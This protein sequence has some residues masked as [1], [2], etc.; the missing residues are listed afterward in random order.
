MKTGPSPK[1]FRALF[2]GAFVLLT[3]LI[4]FG[5]TEK[6]PLDESRC[7]ACHFLGLLLQTAPALV[8]FCVSFVVFSL[9]R[10]SGA[11]RPRMAVAF[12]CLLRA[13]PQI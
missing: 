2:L 12:H 3:L 10:P 7:Q 4:A 6:S 8:A 9:I 5:H 1:L 11:R 13:P